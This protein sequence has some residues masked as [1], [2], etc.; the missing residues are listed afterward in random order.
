M[1]FT[2]TFLLSVRIIYLADHFNETWLGYVIVQLYLPSVYI[3]I[4][5]IATA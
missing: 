4:F 3:S 2:S 1:S 5:L